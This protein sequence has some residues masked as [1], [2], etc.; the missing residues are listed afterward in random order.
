VSVADIASILTARA[1]ARNAATFV[2]LRMTRLR[3]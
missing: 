2:S 1:A 3:A